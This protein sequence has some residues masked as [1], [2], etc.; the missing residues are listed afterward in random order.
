VIRGFRALPIAATI[1]HHD[2]DEARER[3]AMM[4][5]IAAPSA[6][7]LAVMAWLPMSG[8]PA[9]AQSAP[10]PL[11]ISAVDLD[12]NP[13]SM[14]KFLA[15][16]QPDGAAMIQEAGAHEFVST[17][18]QKDPNHVFIFE[19]YSNAAA[20]DAHQKT[21][22]YN[23]FVA[24][25]MLMLKNYNIRPFTAVAM[26]VNPAAQPGP[27]PFFVNQVEL[28]IVPAQFDQFLTAAKANATA[29]LQDPGVREFDIAVSQ[30]DPHHLLFF[31]IYDNAAAHDAHRATDHVKAYQ[32]AT[33]DM[34]SKR[35]VTPLNSVQTLAKSQ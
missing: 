3:I 16:L 23:K 30:T 12:I 5:W 4:K 14:T 11:Y 18:G 31:E 19:V 35:A 15:A 17:T 6:A 32:S 1:S 7:A 26:N 8:H 2:N 21:A 27:G 34:V 20:Y 25:S 10:A 13:S 24:I 22:A 29:A 28:D 33:K 9:R